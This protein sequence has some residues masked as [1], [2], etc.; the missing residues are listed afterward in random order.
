MDQVLIRI[1]ADDKGEVGLEY[2]ADMVRLLPRE[3]IVTLTT[4][5][6]LFPSQR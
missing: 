6:L 2:M 5:S 4:P 3:E 1:V